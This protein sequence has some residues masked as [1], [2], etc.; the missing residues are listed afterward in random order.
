MFPLFKQAVKLE[1][2]VEGSKIDKRRDNVF[3]K[4]NE[5]EVSF[6]DYAKGSFRSDKEVDEVHSLLRKV[7]GIVF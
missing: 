5:H 7:S 4:G 1:Q 3:W 6:G 2:I